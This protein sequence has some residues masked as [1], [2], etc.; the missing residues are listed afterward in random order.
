MSPIT[1]SVVR[2]TPGVQIA[3]S[4]TLPG[5][6]V[7]SASTPGT[8]IEIVAIDNPSGSTVLRYVGA[9]GLA[10]ATT[11]VLGQTLQVGWDGL[12]QASGVAP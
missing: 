5:G 2:V 4:A 6:E 11:F 12:I 1:Y 3:T 10:A 9:D 7:V 8:E